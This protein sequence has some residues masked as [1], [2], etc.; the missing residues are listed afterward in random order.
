MSI[1]FMPQPSG[2]CHDNDSIDRV[3]MYS[4]DNRYSLLNTYYVPDTVLGTL[5]TLSYLNGRKHLHLQ[6]KKLK[7]REVK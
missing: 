6:V 5:Y 2:R 4:N 3:Y 7:L 1:N